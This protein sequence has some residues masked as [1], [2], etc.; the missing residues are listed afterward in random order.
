MIAKRSGY[1]CS[2]PDC[3]NPT[4]GAAIG[5][6]NAIDIGVAAHITAA[7]PGGPRYDAS[8]T[9]SERSHYTNGIW[10]CANHAKAIDS[11][12]KHFTVE[13]L[14][15]WRTSAAKQSF[16]EIV[17]SGMAEAP[18]PT[19]L[20]PDEQELFRA[21]VGEQETLDGIKARALKAARID[22]QS[23]KRGNSW[24]RHPVELSL[25]LYDGSS[26]RPFSVQQLSATL[27][28]F[29]EILIISPPGTG[30]TT[31]LFQVTEGVLARGETIAAFVPLGEWSTQTFSLLASIASRDSFTGLSEKHLRALA[32]AGQLCLALDGW[33]EL[34]D[35]SRV[36]LTAEIQKLQRDYP[37]LIVVVST[38][39]QAL[40][41]PL[42]SPIRIEIDSLS[43][44]SQLEIATALRGEDGENLL[45]HAWRT[46][47]VRDLVSIP[48]YLTALLTHVNGQ[49]LPET[50]EAVLRMFVEEH[51]RD[52]ANADKLRT[53]LLG[54]HNRFLTAL[55]VEASTSSN[56][57]ISDEKA[58][59]VISSVGKMLVSEGQLTIQIEP[60]SVLDTLV[61]NH[62][63]TRS[64]GKNG[65]VGFQHQQIQ[66]WFSSFQ[67]E[68]LMLAAVADENSLHTLRSAILNVPA[69]E[70][71]ILF[72]AERLSR[73][74]ATGC[75]AVAMAILITMEIDPMLAAE[76]IYRSVIETW[77]EVGAAVQEYVGRWHR[78]GT[79][80]RAVGFMIRT[81][82]P[83]FATVVW[84][85]I[86]SSDD[87]VHLRVLR[88][89]PR[90]RPSVLGTQIRDALPALPESTRANILSEMAMQGGLEGMELSADK[91]HADSSD[92]VKYQV[93][94][95][96]AFRR[97]DKLVA[98]VL[99]GASDQVWKDVARK[100][101][102]EG[103]TVP[104]IAARLDAERATVLDQMSPNEQLNALAHD[105]SIDGAKADLV[106]RLIE[107]SDFQAKDQNGL[108]IFER[109]RAR[110]PKVVDNAIV[111]RVTAGLE[112]PYGA[113]SILRSINTRFETGPIADS[114]LDA[115]ATVREVSE[116]VCLVGP[117]VV[118]K[119]IDCFIALHRK[120]R[121]AGNKLDQTDTTRHT[122]L[123]WL[124][125]ATSFVPFCEAFLSRANNDDPIVIATLSDLFSRHGFFDERD[126]AQI[127]DRW[128][129]QIK[130]IVEKWGDIL[131]SNTNTSRSQLSEL[132]RMISR[133][134]AP[135]FLPLLL[136]MRASD[137]AG[138]NR[139]RQDAKDARAIGR[140]PP[141]DSYTVY[142]NT[143]SAAFAAIGTADTA[144][145]MIS[146]LPDLDFGFE[147]ATVLL[148]MW[149]RD[150]VNEGD[151]VFVSGFNPS[152]AKNNYLRTQR[153]AASA[154]DSQFA[155]ALFSV[156]D[157]LS[158]ATASDEERAHALNLSRIAIRLPHAAHDKEIE[159]L[160]ALP[161]RRRLKLGLVIGLVESGELTSAD[162]VVTQISD[163][164][165]EA[166]TATWKLRDW[167]FELKDW[168]ALL[169]FS[170]RPRAVLD[171]LKTL[172]PSSAS[173]HEL[174]RLLSALGEAPSAEAEGVLFELV[175]QN[176]KFYEEFAWTRAV[177][178]RGTA[179]AIRG[180]L[181][182]I[183][184]Q[185][186]TMRSTTPYWSVSQGIV[187]VL[188]SN[189]DAR[190]A[191]YD[192]CASLPAGRAKQIAEASIAESGDTEA[193]LFLV[194]QY[195]EQKRGFDAT[196]STALRRALVKEVPAP[197]GSNY[198]HL[199]SVSAIDLRKTLFRW[200]VTSDATG[201]PA[202]RTLKAIDELRDDYGVAEAEPRH[203]DIESG[204]P[205]PLGIQKEMPLN[206]RDMT[207]E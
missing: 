117:L 46:S 74:D 71:A 89:A 56:T 16:D 184:A 17:K 48:L 63:L 95:A 164:L 153:G 76:V 102:P 75:H 114:V 137:D 148:R 152:V 45:D 2:N 145:A 70:E 139:A 98:K 64:F 93:I 186:D 127:D 143:Y 67:V 199:H 7:S 128:L 96:L 88:S 34:D 206:Q 28:S 97:S 80:D 174:E 125:G 36:R 200:S 162:F 146:L 170:D 66:E 135:D 155:A 138:W 22:L 151:T 168:L 31:T 190:N 68:T 81:G 169:A 158:V 159:Y 62:A 21:L 55:A 196:I 130:P 26:S 60:M 73:S 58:R 52:P 110:L 107:S 178:R 82:R 47:G 24:P 149:Q 194:K 9:Q 112:M 181:E 144:K 37:G 100:G 160:L 103:S 5:S 44:A 173:P 179:T 57:S 19:S 99:D 6:D 198:G 132:V 131:L 154:E 182:T 4:I 113:N 120:W 106:S 25:Q 8:L 161:G 90:F 188:R 203:P 207:A 187:P 77:E 183:T 205:W 175:D 115:A 29:N 50:K 38:R 111:A 140:P 41:V 165:E 176:P 189:A 32:V 142:S 53:Q 10:L 122:E 101:F 136:R 12:V 39:R 172:P 166:N 124:I 65:S 118:G 51:E 91:G 134:P 15:G 109:L 156:I 61:A 43:E 147:A 30:K 126:K 150:N 35:E 14:Q 202:L 195:G 3:R 33:N 94:E 23:F 42:V 86:S 180:L 201:K 108:Y 105:E 13:L 197:D 193:I 123:M 11:D 121:D 119:L 54:Q 204:R 59:T 192:I 133:I 1:R 163:F 104:L 177:E 27:G 78:A 141:P 85:L 72:A 40:Q 84:P 185:G 69:W 129:S 157:K 92:K 87:Q 116:Q 191:I 49:A 167:S 18:L 79:F 83:E 171:V 20:S